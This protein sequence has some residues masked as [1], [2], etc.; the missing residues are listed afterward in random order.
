MFQDWLTLYKQIRDVRTKMVDFI[1]PECGS[2]SIDFQYVGDV[3]E[4]IGYLD[5]WCTTC[6]KGVHLSRVS[7][8]AG[9]PLIS[10]DDPDEV[11]VAR[12]PNFEPVTNQI[13][14]GRGE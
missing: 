7:I 5:M 6:N 4:R 11:L 10:F 2:S 1:C 3:S 13:D 9:A 14:K 8:P 12:I